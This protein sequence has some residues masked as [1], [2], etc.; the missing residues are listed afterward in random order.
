MKKSL[1]RTQTSCSF[2]SAL[3]T[4][5]ISKR[6][7]KRQKTRS[8]I[9]EV[10]KVITFVAQGIDNLAQQLVPTSLILYERTTKIGPE[11]IIKT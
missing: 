10:I 1:K 9:E 7:C 5:T 2:F 4:P 8:I 3:K 6:F 11:T